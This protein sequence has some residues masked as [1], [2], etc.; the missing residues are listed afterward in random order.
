MSRMA[1]IV[2]DNGVA[3]DDFSSYEFIIGCFHVCMVHYNGIVL[4]DPGR[5]RD[6]SVENM[7]IVLTYQNHRFLNSLLYLS[8]N[9]LA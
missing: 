7:Y 4:C 3:K 9:S 6:G 1:T 8:A 5:L 2:E